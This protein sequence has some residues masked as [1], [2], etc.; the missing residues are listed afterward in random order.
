ML[1]LCA[2]SALAFSPTMRPMGAVVSARVQPVMQDIP[3]G[4]SE[5]NAAKAAALDIAETEAPTAPATPSAGAA[6]DRSATFSDVELA[7]QEAKLQALSDK[8]KRREDEVCGRGSCT[9][10]TSIKS[11]SC[12]CLF[13]G[14]RKSPL[15]LNG[16]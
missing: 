15:Y 13:L 7:E 4:G 12:A 11:P 6:A 9:F 14:K 5:S 3:F 10:F 1:S 2:A 8:W 16:T